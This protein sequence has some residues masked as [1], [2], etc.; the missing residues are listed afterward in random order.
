MSG[1]DGFAPFDHVT[2]R[3]VGPWRDC[4]FAAGLEV[5]RDG[6]PDGVA[7]PPTV[8]EKEALRAA[9]GLPDDHS[10]AT[11]AQLIQAGQKRYGLAGGYFVTRDWA[12][13]RTALLV[14]G[15]RLV[16][17]GSMAKVPAS[18]RR[19]DPSFTGAHAV[20]ARGNATAPMWCDPLAPKGTYAGEPVTIST[21]Q[22]Y[23]LGLPGAQAFI[24]EV[25]ALTRG[26]PMAFVFEFSRWK[27]AA[28][29]PFYDQPNG[30]AIGKISNATTVT[31]VGVPL[32]RSTDGSPGKDFAWRA[33]LVTSAAMD[34]V[35]GQKAV[36]IKRT[37]LTGPVPT[38]SEWDDFVISAMRDPE[39]Y[40]WD[41]TQP[42]PPDG[43][44]YSQADLDAAVAR[45]S[46]EW[47]AWVA[48]RPK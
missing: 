25:G 16:V 11:I 42:V 10:G 27:V 3:E 44:P 41:D 39:S 12:D 20:A 45:E 29:V 31:S 34:K 1:G 32:D 9:A 19:W 46:A 17:Q 22:S 30:T 23:F 47:E 18:L 33:V 26:G 15:F 7:I 40:K 36:Y 21:W 43:T 8:E 6:F 2:E 4:T 35:L 48:T 37:Q 38:S 5:F 13:V 28:G 24:T 14:P